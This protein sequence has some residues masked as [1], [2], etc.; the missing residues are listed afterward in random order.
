MKPVAALPIFKFKHDR[1]V[2][3]RIIAVLHPLICNFQSNLNIKDSHF[4]SIGA[5]VVPA[6]ASSRVDQR[7]SVTPPLSND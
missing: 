2:R 5:E 4:L 6:Q 7:F 3:R 1:Q